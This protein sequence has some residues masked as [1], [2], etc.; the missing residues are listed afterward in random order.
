MSCAPLSQLDAHHYFPARRMDGDATC[1]HQP[2]VKYFTRTP[3]LFF[4][5]RRCI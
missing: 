1:I 5:G 3:P 2:L 4:A